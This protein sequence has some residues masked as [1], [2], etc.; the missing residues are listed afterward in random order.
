MYVTI[1][2]GQ[3][4]VGSKCICSPH[5]CVLFILMSA[6]TNKCTCKCACA[7]RRSY[8]KRFDRWDWAGVR[9]SGV[10]IN[11]GRSCMHLRRL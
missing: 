3:V 1:Y 7:E 4:F 5:V 11:C 6:Y 8:S 9:I 10:S 2:Q